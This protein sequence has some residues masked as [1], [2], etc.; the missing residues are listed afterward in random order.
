M[1]WCC[2]YVFSGGEI[3][4]SE[5]YLYELLHKIFAFFFKFCSSKRS[6][7]FIADGVP[8]APPPKKYSP[9]RAAAT[10]RG[11]PGYQCS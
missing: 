6:V 1:E 11:G 4:E 2:E 8:Q 9:R 7:Y 5:H 10:H 3:R